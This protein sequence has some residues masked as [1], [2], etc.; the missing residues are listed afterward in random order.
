MSQPDA[1]FDRLARI[2]REDFHVPAHAITPDTHLRVD[3][4]LDSLS[5]TDLAFLVQRDLGFSAAAD[6]LRGVTTVG[7]LVA[8]CDAKLGAAPPTG[9]A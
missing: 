1:T 5:L 4:G 3:L 7:A 2:L 9:L 8:F 6:E